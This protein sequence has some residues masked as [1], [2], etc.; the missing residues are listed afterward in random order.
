MAGRYVP[1]D[2]HRRAGSPGPDSR[3]ALPDTAA[4]NRAR[5]ARILGADLGSLRREKGPPP[6]RCQH[7]G[8]GGRWHPFAWLRRRT[9]MTNN[10]PSSKVRR[11]AIRMAAL[12]IGVVVMLSHGRVLQR[13]PARITEDNRSSTRR[14]PVAG[15]DGVSRQPGGSGAQRPVARRHGDLSLRGE[16]TWRAS[17]AGTMETQRTL[18][19]PGCGRRP[20]RQDDS[21]GANAR[22]EQLCAPA[23]LHRLSVM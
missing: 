2:R 10:T 9:M 3:C 17:T 6:R 4:L 22:Q 20:R 5:L 14:G 13:R 8:G 11:S 15:S 1:K 7:C 18:S 16:R 21:G 23:R 19:T 12:T